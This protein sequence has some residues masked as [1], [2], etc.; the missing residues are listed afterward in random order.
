MASRRGLLAD[1]HGAELT[2]YEIHM[3]V[4]LP[5]GKT[6]PFVIET[7]SG[8]PAGSTDGALDDEGLTLGTYMHGLFHNR[9]V[10]RSVIECAAR[11]K[12]VTLH[13]SATR[14][15]RTP[16]TTSWPRWSASTLDMA[17]IR[18]AMGL[19]LRG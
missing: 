1:A 19:T 16:S 7:R 9:D 18:R 5:N 10:R 14:S 6:S 2:G 13:L 8:T 17:H 11:R 15:I 4:P 3:G 12:G